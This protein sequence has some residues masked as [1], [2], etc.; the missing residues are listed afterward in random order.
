MRYVKK[1]V[2]L[3]IH[4]PLLAISKSRKLWKLTLFVCNSLVDRTWLESELIW[5]QLLTNLTEALLDLV[6]PLLLNIHILGYRNKNPLGYR[7]VP[8][9]WGVTYRHQ[10]CVSV[11]HTS[12]QDDFICKCPYFS[13]LKYNSFYTLDKLAYSTY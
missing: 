4:N 11:C 10:H 9:P 5:W 6:M 2:K 1:C 12:V 7:A 3:Q 8:S 13:I